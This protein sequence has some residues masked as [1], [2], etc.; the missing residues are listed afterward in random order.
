M[1]KISRE[2]LV[3]YDYETSGAWAYVLA[4]SEEQVGELFPELRIITE[5][6]SWLNEEEDRR[7]KERMS[8]DVTDVDHPFLAALI[9]ARPHSG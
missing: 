3:A 2:F 9:R 7:I 8:I 5:R 4:D 1:S 6:P